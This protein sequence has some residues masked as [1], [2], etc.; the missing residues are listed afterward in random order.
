MN[1]T[2]IADILYADA[3][4]LFMLTG[5]FCAIVRWS[6]MCRP[7]N[8]N[9]EYYYPARRQLT[10]F[11]ACVVMQFPYFFNPSDEGVWCYI[12]FFGI[13]YYPMCYVMLYSRYFHGR[14]LAGWSDKLFFAVPMLLV[15][16]M[17]LASVQGGG[18]LEKQFGWL[19]YVVGAL[20]I[21]LTLK[22][23]DVLKPIRQSIRSYHMQ[24]YSSEEDFPYRFAEK[25]IALPLVWIAMAWCIC[26]SGS[27]DVKL[28]VDIVMSAGMLLVLCLVLHPQRVGQVVEAKEPVL[29][30]GEC[31]APTNCETAAVGAGG[32]LTEQCPLETANDEVV[33]A[34]LAVILRK[35]RK[36]HLR[37][38]EVLAEIDKGMIA[39]ASRFIAQAGYYN[40]IN[41]FRLRHAQLYIEA[42]PATKLAEAALQSG[43]LSA[44]AFSKAKKNIKQVNP[45]YVA[46]VR[47]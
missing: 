4:F 23:L 1:Y 7:Y 45:E 44:S 21:L 18:W 3:C 37:K 29:D 8:D 30:D 36:P 15:L 11:Y 2:S 43:F 12:R 10:F 46:G 9:G 22:L 25:M 32:N 35:Y 47:I 20:S 41:M 5:V 39:P 42:H 19:R 34:V 13:I 28:V 6:H 27:R 24:N 16:L 33:Q 38:S 17:L 40:L 14:K 26:L 31:A